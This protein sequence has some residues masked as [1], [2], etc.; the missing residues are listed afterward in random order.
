MCACVSGQNS[1]EKKGVCV[2]VCVFFVLFQFASFSHM[3]NTLYEKVCVCVCVHACD[4]VCVCVHACVCVCVCM[5]LCVCVC[6]SCNMVS[7]LRRTRRVSGC[8][9][10][11]CLHHGQ[12]EL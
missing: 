5:C 2:C 6:M 9:V 10:D 8:A 12:P 11:E 3:V 7:A 1:I 4:C